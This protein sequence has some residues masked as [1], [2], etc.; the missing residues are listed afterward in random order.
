ML[1]AGQ[2]MVAA[3]AEAVAADSLAH[4]VVAWSAV[5]VLG[6]ADITCFL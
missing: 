3:A 5:G 2:V 4:S 1:S 6:S